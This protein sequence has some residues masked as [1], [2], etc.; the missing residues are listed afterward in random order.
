MSTPYPAGPHNTPTAPEY[1][2]PPKSKSLRFAIILR[3]V[4]LVILGLVFLLH[5]AQLI[6]VNVFMPS[7]VDPK[8]GFD[9]ISE[10]G[11]WIMLLGSMPAV[12]ALGTAHVIELAARAKSSGVILAMVAVWVVAACA[13]LFVALI[14]LMLVTIALRGVF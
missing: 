5:P 6:F 10:S 11:K 13:A 9:P 2:I 1:Q 8:T 14:V 7:L 4:A 12:G 3:N